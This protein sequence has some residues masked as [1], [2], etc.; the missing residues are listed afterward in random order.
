MFAI[1]MIQSARLLEGRARFDIPFFGRDDVYETFLW[2]SIFCDD[3]LGP[4][5]PS[6]PFGKFLA[7]LTV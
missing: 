5:E 1:D 2:Y 4:G 6:L 7:H 3:A